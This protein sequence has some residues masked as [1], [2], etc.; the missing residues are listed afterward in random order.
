[1]TGDAVRLPVGYTDVL[2]DV[3]SERIGIVLNPDETRTEW[4]RLNPPGRDEEFVV[5]VW[6][7][8]VLPGQDDV[9][10]FDRLEQLSDVVQLCVYDRH[11]QQVRKLGFDGEV[12]VA[13]V[14]AHRFAI[15]PS[16]D[17]FGGQAAVAFHFTTRI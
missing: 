9:A 6:I 4:T 15:F 3:G 16:G 5:E 17:G 12:E 7:S 8:T 14:G 13:R 2:P 10:A 11:T 1:V